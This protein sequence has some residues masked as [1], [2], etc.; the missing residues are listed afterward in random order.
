MGLHIRS[1]PFRAGGRTF[2]VVEFSDDG[3]ILSAEGIMI[4]T[5]QTA[6]EQVDLNKVLPQPVMGESIPKLR[7]ACQAFRQWWRLF[8]TVRGDS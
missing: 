2:D 1:P 3:L 6:G 7:A 8:R 4:R 5:I